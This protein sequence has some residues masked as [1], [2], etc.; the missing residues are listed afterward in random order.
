MVSHISQVTFKSA[1]EMTGACNDEIDPLELEEVKTSEYNLGE[2]VPGIGA[3][4]M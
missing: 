1:S 4:G 3:E 2:G